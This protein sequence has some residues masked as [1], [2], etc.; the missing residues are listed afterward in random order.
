MPAGVAPPHVPLHIQFYMATATDRSGDLQL[1]DAQ[2]IAQTNRDLRSSQRRLCV[3]N[4][5]EPRLTSVSR[6]WF[7]RYHWHI[8]CSVAGDRSNTLAQRHALDGRCQATE[9]HVAPNHSV[10]SPLVVA[11]RAST[12]SERLSSFQI[13]K[14]AK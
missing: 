1:V 2:T 10:P 12:T 4:H 7:A 8:D 3:C 13:K 9:R 5:R 11:S 6:G 14:E